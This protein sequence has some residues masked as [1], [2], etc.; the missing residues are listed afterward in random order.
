MALLIVALPL[1]KYLMSVAQ[2]VLVGVFIFDGI[3]KSDVESFL[4]RSTAYQFAL[5]LPLG[6]KWTFE[7]IF[8]KFRK[9]FSYDNLPAVLFS[10]IYFLHVIGL[11][12]SED[13]AYGLKD[14][15][16][17]L[18]VFLLPLI[19]STTGD[20]DRKKFR[21][22]MILFA[23]AVVAG[24]VINTVY[25]YTHSI[26]DPRYISLFIS[27]IR[28]GLLICIAIF[29]LLYWLF[30]IG[31]VTWPQKILAA[32]VIAWLTGY[33][34]LTSSMTGLVILVAAL[35]V[36]TVY[37]LFQQHR[38]I[39]IKSSIL[40]LIILMPV[41]LLVYV[42]SIAK[43]VY[44]SPD[45]DLSSLPQTTAR[46]NLY[47]HDTT[48][49]QVENG[50]YV[51]LFISEP[52]LKEAWN[53]RSQLDYAGSD[54]KGQELKSTLIRFLASKGYPKDA[55]GVERLTDEE[56]EMI[57]NGTASIV[58]EERSNLYVRIYTIIWEYKRYMETANPSGHS[59]MQRFEYWRASLMIIEENF[60][61][62]VG[63]GDLNKAFLTQ[64][65][66]MNSLLDEQFRWRSHNQFLAIFAGL[67]IA[68]LLVFLVSLIGPPVMLSRFSDY[69]YLSFFIIIVISMLSEDTIESQA[70]VTIYAF[71]SSLY[72]F[73]KKFH[74]PV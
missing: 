41:A 46:G 64:Y 48:N 43:D 29:I 36:L 37:M 25:Y 40:L 30:R 16:I 60:W 13:L 24:T 4:G 31:E 20:I 70:G 6:L 7:A 63:T 73:S 69:Y 15:R 50:H 58:Y 34:V 61:V 28:F 68:G 12:W 65:E 27:H 17:K 74:D 55:S 47:W 2:F 51:Y 19:F 23:A 59:V 39:W 9:F 26:D 72:L 11:L 14:L 44:Q 71:F 18:P 54:R 1:S 67:G 5:A 33:L 22:L 35:F 49:L 56:I 66:K 57:E 21:Y 10:S 42:L 45:T 53:E 38:S 3:R 32:V 62:G 52:E 8:R